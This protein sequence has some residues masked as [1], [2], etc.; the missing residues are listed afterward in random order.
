MSRRA[1]TGHE[2]KTAMKKVLI[3]MVMGIING[4]KLMVI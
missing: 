4:Y 2:S 1:T 3:N